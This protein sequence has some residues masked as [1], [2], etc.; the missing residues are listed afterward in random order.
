M[1]DP[2]TSVLF[3]N[4]SYWPDVEAT[5]QLLT[6]LCEGLSSSF[7][8]RVLA[9]QPNA[10]RGIEGD[11]QKLWQT[12]TSHNGV[13]IHRARH[14]QLSKHNML[15]KGLNYLS[16][17]SATRRALRVIERPDVVVFETDPFLLPFEAARLQRRTGCRMVGYLQDIYPDVAVAL[18][19][20]PN[21]WG[22]RRLRTALFS[23]YRRCDRMVVLSEDMKRLLIAGGVNPERI[24]LVP[25]WSDPETV[26][27]ITQT[28]LFRQRHGLEDRF[29]VMYSGNLGLTQRLEEFVEAAALLTDLPQVLFAFVG[30]GSQRSQLQQMVQRKALS[31]LLFFDYQPKAELAHSLSAADLHLVPL[32][33]E[34]SQCLMPSKLYGI[35]AA[36]RP[37]LTNAVPESE[38]H[39][40]TVG[41]QVG[42]SVEPGSPAAIAS[43]IRHAVADAPLLARMGQNA[44]QLA[45]T[46]FTREKSVE[47]F[48]QVLRAALAGTSK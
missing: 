45:V 5:G 39:Q 16:F 41:H 27:P 4:R 12:A 2:K 34:L 24:D 42:I 32:T 18:G 8:V 20:V 13:R 47:K 15:L 40:I 23:V 3:L 17:V 26:F 35:L 37:Y 14:W 38:L 7:D 6:E 46:E 1:P 21:H 44:R 29:L 11:Q 36:G 33:K 30:Q 10:V 25:N 43:A 48:R 31:N 22:I 28:N 9:G 19:K